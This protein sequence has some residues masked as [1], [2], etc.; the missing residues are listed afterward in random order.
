M[1]HSMTSLL[2]AVGPLLQLIFVC[3]F[4]Q[5]NGLFGLSVDSILSFEADSSFLRS[6][7]LY[8]CMRCNSVHLITGYVGILLDIIGIVHLDSYLEQWSVS[9]NDLLI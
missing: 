4:I 5:L 3:V 8:S 7:W 6:I 9:S 2:L 1:M